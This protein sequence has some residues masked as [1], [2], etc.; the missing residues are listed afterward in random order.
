MAPHPIL[1]LTWLM[2]IATFSFLSADPDLLVINSMTI[3]EEIVIQDIF[4][5][6]GKVVFVTVPTQQEVDAGVMLENKAVMKNK[7]FLTLEDPWG[8]QAHNLAVLVRF[9]VDRTESLII[10]ETYH[11][12]FKKII[13]FQGFL[14]ITA[15]FDSMN[16]KS[17][18]LGHSKPLFLRAKNYQISL[19]TLFKTNN[20]KDLTL[21]IE[22]Y[23]GLGVENFLLYL[24]G[25]M[26]DFPNIKAL[27]ERYT[28]EG[29][30]VTFA[31][32]NYPYMENGMHLAQVTAMH[33][34]LHRLRCFTTWLMYFDTDEYII[35]TSPF[36][37]LR[38][39]I[40]S[41]PKN[42]AI[43][44][45]DSY[46]AYHPE[47]ASSLNTTQYFFRKAT[48]EST[49]DR[50]YTKFMIKPSIVQEL[51]VHHP[52]KEYFTKVKVRVEKDPSDYFLHFH[53]DNHKDFERH[54]FLSPK[55]TSL[56]QLDS[57]D[58]Y[59]APTGTTI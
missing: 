2:L 13:Q 30:P 51:N 54:P 4:F 48:Y 49:P 8:G 1:C 19:F 42:T 44:M 5:A 20:D 11:R 31:E 10:G 29:A 55:N 37:T 23:R 53:L 9:L 41:L 59:V 27:A 7:G 12:L 47:D 3:N 36:S 40:A 35:P 50:H 39:R 34:A 26:S 18:Q 52:R 15:R 38:D 57:T 24:N 46:F 16:Y 21:W 22:Y 14:T 33:S 32:W 17:F 43:V 45:F 6:C 25:V 58:D 28:K 56:L